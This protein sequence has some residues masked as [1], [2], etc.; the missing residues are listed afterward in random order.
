MA[1][2]FQKKNATITSMHVRQMVLSAMFL[3]IALVIRTLFRM[4]IPLF[5][6]S[7]IRISVHQIFSFMP[8]ILFGPVYGAIVA[9]LTD[10]LGHHLSPTGAYIPHLTATAI[11]GGFARGGLWMILKNKSNFMARS[12]VIILG[13]IF[14]SAGAINMM[15]LSNDGLN[16][17]F[18]NPYITGTSINEAG[19]TV[20]EIDR[21]RID[22]NN[23]SI[24][25]RMAI[26]RSQN[27]NN[28]PNVLREFINLVTFTMMG[29]GVF[30][31]LLVGIDWLVGLF[32]IKD[33][34][35]IATMPLLL[36]LVIPSAV[37]NT[38]NT[39]ILRQTAMPSW[40]L[41][42]FS[43]IWLPR[44]I[45]AIATTTLVTYFIA[46]LLGVLRQQPGFRDYFKQ[47]D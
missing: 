22:V 41:L 3:A 39:E 32:I 5:G 9:G 34:H 16:Q 46:V 12:V 19:V 45:Q 42:P 20:I 11:F 24:I 37:V 28:P 29:T 38:L 30:G 26:I 43:V 14:L 17:D 1:S 10:F 18:Y 13:I 8:A 47:T 44:V 35:G 4:Y 25:G 40:Q 36:A 7:G 2:I 33:A 6:E 27:A 21:D 23:F 15:T 31:L